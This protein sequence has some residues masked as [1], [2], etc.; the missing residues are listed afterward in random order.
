V[1][2]THGRRDRCCALDGRALAAALSEI[3]EP[4]VWECSHLGGHRFAPTA[5]VLPTGY[6]YGRLDP[7]TAVAAHKAAGVGEVEPDRCRGR[8]TWSPAGQVAEL[9]VRALTGWRDAAALSVLPD[10]G[11]TVEVRSRTGERWRVEVERTEIG[12]R[13]PVS[14]GADPTPITPVRAAAVRLLPA[15]TRGDV[16]RTG[17]AGAPTA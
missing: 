3:H 2:C 9:A 10:H 14:C 17:P 7:A 4:S 8:S 15:P 6:L 5:L 13:R 16:T 12:G 11:D 1:V